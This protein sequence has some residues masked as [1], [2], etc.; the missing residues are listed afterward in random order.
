MINYIRDKNLSWDQG[1][2]ASH[3]P[4]NRMSVQEGPRDPRAG[5]S[6]SAPSRE[7]QPS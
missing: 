4:E 3:G 5:R 2:Q 7:W 6:S 1:Q